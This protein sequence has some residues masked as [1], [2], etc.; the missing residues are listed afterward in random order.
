MYDIEYL[1]YMSSVQH[2]VDNNN[3]NSNNHNYND[4]D[5]KNNNDFYIL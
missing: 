1:N 5:D 2:N 3:D 4:N